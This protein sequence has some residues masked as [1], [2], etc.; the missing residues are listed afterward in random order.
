MHSIKRF[1]ASL[2]LLI[3]LALSLAGC[4][5]ID[6][7]VTIN[8]DGSGSYTLTVG[9]SEQLVSLASD[10][11]S[12]S[13]DSFGQKV[14][15][16]GGSYRHYDDTGYSY[17]AYTRP[18]KS[19]AD[20]NQLVQEAPQ[21]GDTAGS[22]GS[23]SAIPTVGQTDTL[24]FTEQSGFLSNTF[25]VTGHMSMIFPQSAT[26][27]GG[28]D[29]SSYLSD[30]RESFSV[31]MPG[32]ITSHKGGSV[33][34]DTVSYTIHYG[35][36][37]DIDVI[38]GGFNPSHLLPIGVAFVVIL[39]LIGGLI[40]WRQRRNMAARIT[41]VEPAFAGAAP[42]ALTTPGFGAPPESTDAGGAQG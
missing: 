32:S 39:L 41:P 30:M 21:T 13:M 33:S 20:L 14:K 31:T 26:D 28:I 34:G 15:S 36:E 35:Q 3:A 42:G 25:H 8:S 29:V 12:N 18:F 10:Q 9:F 7:A 23:G 38:G 19:I 17:W 1:S 5:H 11:I 22:S 37:T 27:T 24:N 4:V 6:R 40:F 16:Q 2:T